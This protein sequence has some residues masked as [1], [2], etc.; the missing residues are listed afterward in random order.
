LAIF[1]AYKVDHL[2]NEINE[3]NG[4]DGAVILKV[5]F[6]RQS[7][8]HFNADIKM[9]MGK[10]CELCYKS[11]VNYFCGIYAVFIK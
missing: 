10:L 8:H 4:M 6:T 11:G 9:M 3:I 2:I 7:H 5:T 1:P